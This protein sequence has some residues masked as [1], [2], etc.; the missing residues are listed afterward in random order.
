V[1]KRRTGSRPVVTAEGQQIPPALVLSIF[2]IVLPG[3][4]ALLALTVEHHNVRPRFFF[5][6]W[7]FTLLLVPRGAATLSAWLSR[8]WHP[9]P[10]EA[11]RSGLYAAC[12]GAIIL[13]SLAALGPVYRTAKQDVVGAMRFVESAPSAR[14][15]SRGGRVIPA[16][17]GPEAKTGAR[18]IDPTTQTRGEQH[19][20]SENRVTS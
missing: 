18:S 3:L 11:I 15:T 9:H 4:F 17:A 5:Y 10:R 7:G 6:G 2:T 1:T 13:A 8:A 20:P 16:G 14:R 19:G 12:I